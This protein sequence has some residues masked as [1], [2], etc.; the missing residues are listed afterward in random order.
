LRET[1]L[2]EAMRRAGVGGV[3]A[4]DLQRIFEEVR[5]SPGAGQDVRVLQ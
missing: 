4:P 5:Q 1:A 2:P 3:V